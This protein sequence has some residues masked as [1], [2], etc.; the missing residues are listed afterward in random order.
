MKIASK[1]VETQDADIAQ[2]ATREVNQGIKQ[3]VKR[4]ASN[5]GRCVLFFSIVSEET[6]GKPSFPEYPRPETLLLPSDMVGVYQL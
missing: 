1:Y 3:W 6:A 4:T 5:P 2:T